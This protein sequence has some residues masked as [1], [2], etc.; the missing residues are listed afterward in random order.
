M[1]PKQYK[2][3]MR[4]F[5]ILW[6]LSLA[7]I[8]FL[9][10]S[11][12]PKQVEVNNYVGQRGSTGSQGAK[13]DAGVGL[14]GLQ[15]VAGTPGKNAETKVIENNT[16]VY[17]TEVVNTPVPGEKGET[18]ERGAEGREVEFQTSPTGDIEWRYTGTRGWTVLIP[19]DRLLEVEP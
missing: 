4:R 12:Y 3:F 16:T 18:G 2:R 8:F 5:I 14:Q 15:G 1:D 11:F 10:F 17:K 9:I 7:S 13:G 6:I 19:G